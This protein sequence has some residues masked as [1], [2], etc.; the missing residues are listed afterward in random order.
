M[1]EPSTM[2]LEAR[3]NTLV[4]SE[5]TGIDQ[6]LEIWLIDTSNSSRYDKVALMA[7]YYG[8][9]RL[10]TSD[11]GITGSAFDRDIDFK[12]NTWYRLV[13]TGSMTQQVRASLYNDDGTTEIIGVNLGHNLS[14]YISGF[15]I[16]ISQSMGHP[17][18]VYP[19][20]VAVDWV[21]LSVGAP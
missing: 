20:D 9:G 19:T 15:K 5:K 1:P 12:D 11:S 10:F 13:I 6:L 3:F 17:G 14:A 2:R 4:Q 7:P 16:G 21:S 18:A 8:T